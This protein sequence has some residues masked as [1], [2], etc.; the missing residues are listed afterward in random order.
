VVGFVVPLV[1]AEANPDA[2]EEEAER[3]LRTRGD[4]INWVVENRAAG[5]IAGSEEVFVGYI[6]ALLAHIA[7]T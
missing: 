4:V 5:G 1:G 6:L 3:A 2:I 7:R